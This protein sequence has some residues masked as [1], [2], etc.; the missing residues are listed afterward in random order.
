MK[1]ISS[2]TVAAAVTA[3]ATFSSVAVAD[4]T[5]RCESKHHRYQHC[6]IDTHGYV[7]LTRQLSNADC[8]QGRTW[9]YDRRGIW[10]DDGCAAEFVVESR[11][12][13]ED[14][15]DH[16]GAEAAAAVAALAL[17][18][19]A[20]AASDDDHDRYR[21]TDYHHGGHSSYVPGWMIGEFSGYNLKYGAD[22]SMHIKPDGRVKARVQGTK[23]T[24]Y[25]NDQRLYIGE[26]EFYID[27]AGDGFNTTQVGDRA[28]QVHYR[29]DR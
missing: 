14:H 23:L 29:R 18:A 6:P 21:D 7:R 12:H 17:I 9:D 5:I 22:V 4:R 19:V 24:G 1:L 2:A 13:T 10:V 16:K 11:H 3:I 25:V 15:S 20:A 28:N 27:R 26:A 8:R